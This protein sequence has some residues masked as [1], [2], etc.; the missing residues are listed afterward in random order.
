MPKNAKLA[1]RLPDPFH[2]RRISGSSGISSRMALAAT[3]YIRDTCTQVY[4]ASV[5]LQSNF[6]IIIST[7]YLHSITPRPINFKHIFQCF[8]FFRALVQANSFLLEGQMV[9]NVLGKSLG[10]FVCPY[11]SAGEEATLGTMFVVT[12]KI[13][14]AGFF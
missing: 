6:C 13:L 8:A 11:I 4:T 14:I 12:Q 1:G 10:T 5:Q 9:G 7:L 3:T 2:D